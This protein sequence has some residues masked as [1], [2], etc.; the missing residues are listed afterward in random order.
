MDGTMKGQKMVV[1]LSSNST[2]LVQITDVP[3]TSD[4]I[5]AMLPGPTSVS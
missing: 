1:D 5:D 2:D 4:G 3:S